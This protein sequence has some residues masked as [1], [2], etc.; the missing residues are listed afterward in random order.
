MYV[1]FHCPSAAEAWRS[2]QLQL[3]PSGFSPNSVFLNIH[4]LIANTKRRSGLDNKSAAF[5]WI[6]WSIWKSRNELV[7]ENSRSS[8]TECANKAI[9]DAQIWLTVNDPEFANS[10]ARSRLDPPSADWIRP[11]PTLIKCNIGM[12]WSSSNGLSG[13]SWITRNAQGTALHQSRRAYPSSSSKRE[14]DLQSLFW[15]VECMYNMCQCNVI[16]ETSSHEVREAILRP[17]LFPDLRH[18]LEGIFHLLSLIG[19][20]S[21]EHVSASQNLVAQKI[22]DS[23]IEGSRSQ[24]YISVGGPAWLR[25]T[26]DQERR[27]SA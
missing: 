8:P 21:L 27:F 10:L 13:A 24:S 7:F 26:L 18:L 16:L 3:P 23:V 9:E 12:A 25:H 17:D 4:F 14:A 1:L 20:W 15:A 2:S 11:Q 6:L 5:P 19:S 22:A